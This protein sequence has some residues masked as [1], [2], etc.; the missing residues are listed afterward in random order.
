[1]IGVFAKVK[2]S[3]T[4]RRI[5]KMLGLT[6][7]VVLVGVPEEKDPRVEGQGIGNAAL[8]YIHDNGSPLQNIPARPFMIPGVQKAQESINKQ[9]LGAI[10][11]H[12]EGNENK[13]DIY[14]NRAGL[15]AQ[16]SIRRVIN[17]GEG[18]T[19]L[20]RATL[21]A[22]LRARKSARKWPKEQR[23]SVMAS[24]HPLIN[25]AQMRNAISYVVVKK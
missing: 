13:V 7:K 10:K 21:L 24:M 3:R 22:R 5:N 8:A 12:L 19:P 20:K 1:M 6:N 18:F 4:N 11:A 15:V 23:E 17:E 9:L 14:L 2:V 25:T 16:N